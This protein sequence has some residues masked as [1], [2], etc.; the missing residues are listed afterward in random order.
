MD[1]MKAVIYENY[2]APEV[3]RL[4]EIEK[5]RTEKQ[6]IRNNGRTDHDVPPGGYP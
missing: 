5:P 2:G 3:L 4:A 1:K 6:V